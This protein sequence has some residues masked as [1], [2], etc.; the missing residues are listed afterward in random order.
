MTEALDFAARG[1]VTCSVQ[2]YPLEAVNEVYE[3][4]KS[5]RVVGRLVIKVV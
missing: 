2:T 4:L 1:L 3:R 5:G